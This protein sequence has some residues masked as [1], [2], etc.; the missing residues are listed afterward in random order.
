MSATGAYELHMEGLALIRRHDYDGAVEVFKEVL[1]IRLRHL[2]IPPLSSMV[3]VYNICDDIMS[4][5][6]DSMIFVVDH[7]TCYL[8]H[9]RR[10]GGQHRILSFPLHIHIH[11]R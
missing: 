4:C 5:C 3:D 11:S 7:Q 10:L 9:L 2:R 8:I 6:D 1:V